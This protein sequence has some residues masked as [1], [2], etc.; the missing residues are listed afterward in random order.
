VH[1]L[2]VTDEFVRPI[3]LYELIALG[4]T[5]LGTLL[6]LADARQK[7]KSSAEAEP[8]LGRNHQRNA[9]RYLRCTLAMV[10]EMQQW[11]KYEKFN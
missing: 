1:L 10:A 4:L 9:F 7:K 3:G 5:V 11:I 6:A 2:P 8:S